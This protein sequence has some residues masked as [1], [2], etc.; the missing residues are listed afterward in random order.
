MF[1]CVQRLDQ[2]HRDDLNR[3]QQLAVYRST[4]ATQPTKFASIGGGRRHAVTELI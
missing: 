4:H 1:C 3:M 2:S